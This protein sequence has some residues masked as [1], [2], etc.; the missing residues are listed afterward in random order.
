MRIGALLAAAL[1]WSWGA[2]AAEH[3][4]CARAIQAAERAEALP[5]SLLGAIGA[6][7][8]GRIDPG[9][10]RVG[11]WPWTINV[12]G[13]GQYFPTKELAIAAVTAARAQGRRSIDVGCLQVNLMHH[14]A[15]FATLDDAFD[16]R[17]NA[18]YA[19]GFLRRL[20]GQTRDWTLAAAAYHSQTPGVADDYRRR[21]VARWTGAPMPDPLRSGIRRERGRPEPAGGYTPEFRARLAQ[22]ASDRRMLRIGMGLQPLGGVR[23]RLSPPGQT[24]RM[25]EAGLSRRTE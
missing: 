7:E 17:A 3:E 25:A 6:V 10:G 19:A 4:L 9:T 20:F 14:P 22:D 15:A 16:P 12:E 23:T 24:W 8:S 13:T 21:V 11:A 5:A 2:A 1:A 18:A